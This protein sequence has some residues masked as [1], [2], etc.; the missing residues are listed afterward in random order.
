MCIIHGRNC[1]AACIPV[2]YVH[3]RITGLVGVRVRAKGDGCGIAWQRQ[4]LLSGVR[5]VILL[6]T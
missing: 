4:N 6:E 3:E 2:V 1:V 5:C